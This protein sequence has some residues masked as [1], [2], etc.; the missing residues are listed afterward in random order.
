MSVVDR[1][2]GWLLVLGAILHAIGSYIAV[3]NKPD[4][5]VWA[6][7]GTLAA[8][9]IASLNLMRVGR[10]ADRTLAWVSAAGSIGWTLV[11]ISVGA[12]VGNFLD[13]NVMYHII[14]G[15]ALT[16]FSLRSAL[17]G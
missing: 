17:H 3:R 13:P 10:P 4:V 8:L 16:A 11:A 12:I 2:F 15:V 7:A 5:L 14:V 6:Q 9:M 1:I